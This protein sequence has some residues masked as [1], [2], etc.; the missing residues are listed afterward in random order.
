[1]A[2][3]VGHRHPPTD[4][5]GNTGRTSACWFVGQRS[6]RPMNRAL[7]ARTYIPEVWINGRKH[8]HVDHMGVY[9]LA[10]VARKSACLCINWSNACTDTDCP[11]VYTMHR[12][13]LV[14][15]SCVVFSQGSYCYEICWSFHMRVR[16]NRIRA[17][18][19]IE[20]WFVQ[21]FVFNY[22]LTE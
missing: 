20:V 1:M 6:D 22:S 19:E 18:Y 12:I 15:S 16:R 17:L 7:S 21:L 4:K 8:S 2:Y 14:G 13:V 5:H 3:Y 10:F 9:I 11:V